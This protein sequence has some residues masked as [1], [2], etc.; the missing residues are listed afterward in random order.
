MPFPEPET[1]LAATIFGGGRESTLR[2]EIARA[3][4]SQGRPTTFQSLPRT[5]NDLHEGSTTYA[6]MH[7]SAG[8]HP[9]RSRFSGG[10][11]DLACNTTRLNLPRDPSSRLKCA[12]IRDDAVQRLV[13]LNSSGALTKKQQVP[14]LRRPFP[15]GR[16]CCGRDDRVR[17]DRVRYDRVRDDTRR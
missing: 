12:G 6:A 8:R 15:S 2:G 7:S 9:D 3:G 1:A 11:K 17:V 16:T 13:S 4:A 14:P 10:G 5:F